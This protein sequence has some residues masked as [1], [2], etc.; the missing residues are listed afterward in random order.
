MTG[1]APAAT[2]HGARQEVVF[3]DPA[4]QGYEGLVAGVDPAVEAA[5]LALDG[6]NADPDADGRRAIV[7]VALVIDRTGETCG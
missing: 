7:D 5:A 1:T 3:I 4:V 2:T 6:G